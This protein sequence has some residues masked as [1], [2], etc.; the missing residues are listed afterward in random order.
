MINQSAKGS[1]ME[2]LCLEEL[3][4]WIRQGDGEIKATWKV[5][6]GGGKFARFQGGNDFLDGYDIAILDNNNNL[7]LVQVKSKYSNAEL[8]R[9]KKIVPNCSVCYL[10]VYN[11][12]GRWDI[13]LPH[14]WLV[15]V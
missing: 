6:R 4:T 10:A 7:F 5:K 2:K 12:P 1:R 13:K 9:L 8:F 11:T 3:S 14:F 15:K